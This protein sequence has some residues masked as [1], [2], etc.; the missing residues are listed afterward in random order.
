[1]KTK[2]VI[3]SCLMLMVALWGSPASALFGFG[4]TTFQEACHK[5]AD[6][7]VE[8]RVVDDEGHPVCGASVNAFFDMT[9]RS[10]G[11]R[12]IVQTDTNGVCVAE[13][14]TM[15]VIEVDVSREGF[16]RSGDLISFINMGHEH[17]VKNGKWQPWGMVKK[18]TLLP[19][20][21]PQARIADTPKWM[22][23]KEINKW[24]GFDLVRYDYVKPYGN[25][26]YADIEVFFE[27]D[28]ALGPKDYQGMALKIR[29][30]DKYAG[31]YYA[32]KTPGSE[33]VGVYQADTH[34][35]YKTE[36]TYS[37]R[38]SSR[39]KRGY[40]SSYERH[41]FDPSKVLVARSR[42]KLNEDGTL[43]TAQYFQLYGIKF[44]GDN[45]RGAALLC[46]SIFNPTPNDTNLEPK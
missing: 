12:V 9:D 21:N 33:Y 42:C 37:E 16:Y 30:L 25:G 2:G 3:A 45:K 4:P 14:K 44:S 8:F 32:D 35:D 40:A 36:F 23:T 41:F 34:G 28:G 6:A 43:K 5:G 24:I 1:M 27:W 20:K 19:V 22:W 11:R 7:R 39:N 46:L 29:F 26:D 31:G 10:K 38:V 15:G 17:E 18:I 13:A